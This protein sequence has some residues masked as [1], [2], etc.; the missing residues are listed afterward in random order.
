MDPQKGTPAAEAAITRPDGQSISPHK[1]RHTFATRVLE[2]G[3]TIRELQDL[4]GHRSVA[5][6]EIYTHVDT[7]RL[8]AV[9]DRL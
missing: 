2:H 9:V 7:R 8:Q 1:L 4:L 3:G 5:T 6:T